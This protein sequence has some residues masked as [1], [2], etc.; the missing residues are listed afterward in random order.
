MP[1]C[2]DLPARP[3][4]PALHRG[5][6]GR[7]SGMD[8][9]DYPVEDKKGDAP[10]ARLACHKAEPIADTGVAFVIAE[11]CS[12]QCSGWLHACA[13]VEWQRCGDSSWTAE[14]G[15][16]RGRFRPYS[17]MNVLQGAMCA[18]RTARAG[19]SS[20][21]PQSGLPR[22]LWVSTLGRTRIAWW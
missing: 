22:Q 2:P 18:Q 11:Q 16:A 19:L 20:G 3:D 5:P 7:D 12:M 6:S 4:L 17:E 21:C 1:A 14:H 15:F 10:V 9:L 13:R 8:M